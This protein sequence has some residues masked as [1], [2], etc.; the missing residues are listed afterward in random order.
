MWLWLEMSKDRQ[1]LETA[2][3]AYMGED[4]TTAIDKLN[5]IV[6]RYPRSDYAFQILGKSHHKVGNLQ[7]A[8]QA[9]KKAAEL[10]PKVLGE[11]WTEIGLMLAEDGQ[12]QSA[13]AA[14]EFVI[15][16]APSHADAWRELGNVYFGLQQL[17]KAVEYLNRA[18]KYR[19]DDPRT[20]FLLGLIRDAKKDWKAAVKF[21]EKA[22][23]YGN[24]D[25]YYADFNYFL[26]YTLAQSGKI[27]KAIP[28]LEKAIVLDPN[29]LR[30]WKSLETYY[31]KLGKHVKAAECT[32]VIQEL[33]K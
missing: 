21:F 2:M 15:K 28:Y 14:Y 13:I 10:N 16:N 33:T 4:Y 12:A 17:D 8:Y 11:C 29:Y 19:K 25:Q 6:D 18:L 5:D 32:S 26:G 24:H 27:K 31:K 1:E 7:S 20:Y 23:K 3:R 9:L 30:A 22:V